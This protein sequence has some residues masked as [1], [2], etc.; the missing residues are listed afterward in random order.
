MSISNSPFRGNASDGM[1]FQCVRSSDLK[2]NAAFWRCSGVRLSRNA[3]A[4]DAIVLDERCAEMIV[5]AISAAAQPTTN[6]NREKRNLPMM[7]P[8]S[9]ANCIGL[10]TMCGY[11]SL[12]FC[13]R[14][15]HPAGFRRCRTADAEQFATAIVSGGSGLAHDSQQLGLRRS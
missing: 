6:S 15:R 1:K 9:F 7:C 14:L 3:F 11:E 2:G 10:D 13:N 4:D 5:P 8:P 12:L